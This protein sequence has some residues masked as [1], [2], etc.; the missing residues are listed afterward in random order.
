MLGDGL[1]GI[2]GDKDTDDPGPWGI[3]RVVKSKLTPP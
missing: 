1:D 3:A 2:D